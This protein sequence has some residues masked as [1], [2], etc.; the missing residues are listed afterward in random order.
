MDLQEREEQQRREEQGQEEE[1]EEEEESQDMFAPTQEN[2]FLA[3]REA[4]AP[5]KAAL[6]SQSKSDSRNPFAKKNP[7]TSSPSTQG[8]VFDSVQ[9]DSPAGAGAGGEKRGFGE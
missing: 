4:V 5:L 8:F 1:E 2:P 6:P 7:A 3:K 9:K